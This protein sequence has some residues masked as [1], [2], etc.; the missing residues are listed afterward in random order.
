MK[1]KNNWAE[2]VGTIGE[3]IRFHHQGKRASFYSIILHVQCKIGVIDKI[4]MIVNEEDLKACN[5]HKGVKVRIEGR[6][7]RQQKWDEK[8]QQRHVIIY[9][10]VIK[11]ESVSDEE[12]DQNKVYLTGTLY[13][14]SIMKRAYENKKAFLS[15]S[16]ITKVITGETYRIWCVALGE[17]AYSIDQMELQGEIAFFGRF[18]S[19]DYVKGLP[20]GEKE[21]RTT[22]EIFVTELVEK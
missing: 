17:N 10:Q 14:F 21:Q 18:Q 5:A 8:S 15:F 16:I 20:N 7:Q 6:V 1:D 13:D 11:M 3:D 19:R 9:V 22:Y 4:P 2:F 12:Q